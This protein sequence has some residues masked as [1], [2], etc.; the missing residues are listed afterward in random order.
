MYNIIFI[1]PMIVIAL[2]VAFG[3]KNIGELREYKEMNVEKL[4]LIT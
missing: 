4:H 2:V 3:Y 1:I